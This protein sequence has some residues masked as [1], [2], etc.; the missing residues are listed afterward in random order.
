MLGVHVN[1]ADEVIGALTVRVTAIVFDEAPVALTVMVPVRVPVASPAVFT[2]AVNAL[3][4][5]PDAG[6]T[7]SQETSSLTVQFDVPPLV[8]KET[9]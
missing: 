2:L 9:V 7:V 8:V 6:L 3:L 5:L 4:L 1:V